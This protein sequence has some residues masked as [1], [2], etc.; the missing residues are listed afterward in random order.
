M[1]LMWISYFGEQ[2]GVVTAV[3][4]ICLIPCNKDI[5]QPDREKRAYSLVK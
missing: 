4:T 1:F 2:E 3:S 5:V